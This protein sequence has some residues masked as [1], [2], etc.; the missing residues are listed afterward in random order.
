M[1]R[2]GVPEPLPAALVDLLARVSAAYD[3]MDRER[4]RNDRAT[5]LMSD[6]LTDLNS[7]LQHQ[8]GRDSLTGLPNRSLF[9]EWLRN[10]LSVAE[11]TGQAVMLLFVDLNDFKQV[12]DTLGHHFGDLL[13]KEVATR[14]EA[15]IRTG[16]TVARFGGD[17]FTIMMPAI[18]DLQQ[19]AGVAERIIAAFSHRFMLENNEVAVSPAIGI[20]SY[21]SDAT[22]CD[23]L[24][25]A[26]DAAMYRAKD[27]GGGAYHFYTASMDAEAHERTV[28]K[29]R[30]AKAW[31]KG[32]F[33]L[34]YQPKVLLNCGS[35][36]GVEALLRWNSPELGAV[37]PSR[38]IPMMEESGLIVEVGEWVLDESCR[39]S[40]AWSEA[41]AP[42][43]RI[44]VNLSARQLRQPGLPGTVC[45]ILARHGVAPDAVELEIT[46]SMIIRDPEYAI[47]VLNE[48][49]DMG[50][51]IAMDDFGT[52]YSSLSYL[53]R[54]P[55]DSIKIDQS[56]IHAMTGNDDVTA[57]VNAIIGMGHALKRRVVAE[58]VE[59]EAQRTMLGEL[60]AD[61]VQGFAI[62]RPMS[63]DCLAF[64]LMG[65]AAVPLIA[66]TDCP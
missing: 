17:E 27:S 28:L 38:F 32:E 60:K 11:R 66:E 31:T 18:G 50:I 33:F 16:D 65:P 63:P 23:A 44:A 54:F 26:A 47:S 58:G 5:T 7:A 21:P 36:S 64:L 4:R 3:E 2:A 45:D 13:L 12:N 48:L 41:G 25:V 49:R 56:F 35:I 29:H 20:A 55:F 6:E 52:G 9:M 14:L 43:L 30:L 51:R 53:S 46:E 42:P 61:E 59:T 22:T 62:G 1:S 15:C 24:L 34:V 8:V 10:G 40:R 37:P 39:Q 57:I 19:A